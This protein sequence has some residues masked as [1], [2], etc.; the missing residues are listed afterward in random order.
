MNYKEIFKD[1]LELIDG[2]LKELIPEEPK[3]LFSILEEYIMR[4]GKRIRPVLLLT[5]VNAFDGDVEKALIP[6]I[7]IEL[8]HNFTLIHDDIEDD[9]LFRRGKPTLHQTYGIPIALNT[10]DGLYTYIWNLIAS[11]NNHQLT[12]MYAQTFLEVVEGQAYDLW[13]EKYDIFNLNINDYNLLVRKKTGALFGLS[14]GLG[15][16]LSNKEGMYSHFYEF[17]SSLGISFQIIDDILNLFG[18]FDTYKKKIGDDITEGKRTLM[19]IHALNK[20]EKDE[21]QQLIEILKGHYKDENH[22]KEAIKLIEK[23]G[24]KEYA[25]KYAKDIVKKEWNNI[26]PLLP[27]NEHKDKI[28][29]IVNYMINREV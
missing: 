15:V 17:G 27:E 16:V 22:I 4:G 26:K 25:L 24:A 2:K 12:K 3:E 7:I 10:G 13:W 1:E 21:K 5:I 28:K 18:D 29:E 9:S 6:G 23:T 11:L 19:V 20:L 14:A 8:F